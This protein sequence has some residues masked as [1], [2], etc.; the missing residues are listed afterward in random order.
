MF[1]KSVQKLRET[2]ENATPGA[3]QMN[4]QSAECISLHMI[5]D[6]SKVIQRNF[7]KDSGI[8]IPYVDFTQFQTI[9]FCDDHILI[10]LYDQLL[11]YQITKSFELVLIRNV[12]NFGSGFCGSSF[13]L[14]TNVIVMMFTDY[15]GKYYVDENTLRRFRFEKAIG[16]CLAI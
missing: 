5:R 9:E 14:T 1:V 7:E 2:Q 10:N 11:V 15:F 16:K 8:K 3:E 4:S 12:E 13:F 6:L